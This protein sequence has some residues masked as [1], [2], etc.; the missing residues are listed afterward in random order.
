MATGTQNQINN[1]MALYQGGATNSGNDRQALLNQV[2]GGQDALTKS[3]QAAFSAAMPSYFKNLQSLRESN[4]ARGAGTGGL[5]T[6]TEGDLTSAFQR[7]LANAAGS[8]ALGLYNTQTS[9]LGGLL[10]QD[11]Q[12]NDEYASMLG[13]ER[14][15]ET[16]QANARKQRKGGLFGGIGS[17]LG[18]AASFLIPGGQTGAL[19]GLG[20]SIGGALGGGIGGLFG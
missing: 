2:N 3:L 10:N 8:Q 20:S 11:N 12:Q 13:G 4:V 14:D 18:G 16:Q 15:Y 7:N 6:T 19:A 1:L 9:A 5:G 17:L